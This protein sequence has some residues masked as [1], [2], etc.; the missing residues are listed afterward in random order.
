MH[1]FFHAISPLTRS[2]PLWKP[3]PGIQ[4]LAWNA[5]KI[6][7]T[8]AKDKRAKEGQAKDA[9]WSIIMMYARFEVSTIRRIQIT[10][11]PTAFLTSRRRSG[12]L[13]SLSLSVSVS[14]H[15]HKIVAEATIKIAM[16]S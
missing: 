13:F 16:S 2:S 14:G 11:E 9:K 12:P 6:R 15:V 8:L 10:S 4:S 3:L 7:R 1:A 5:I